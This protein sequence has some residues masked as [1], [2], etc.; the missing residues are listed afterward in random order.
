MAKFRQFIIF[1]SYVDYFE[2]IIRYLLL[3]HCMWVS[4]VQPNHHFSH[5]LYACETF[6]IPKF[7]QSLVKHWKTKTAAIMQNLLKH[8]WRIF[9]KAFT[10]VVECLSCIMFPFTAVAFCM[11]IVELSLFHF[12]FVA[13]QIA[14]LVFVL[15]T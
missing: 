9:I 12:F 1:A 10:L 13:F 3:L 5:Y 4:N 2:F 15:I 8:L 14:R 11:I 7:K 6:A